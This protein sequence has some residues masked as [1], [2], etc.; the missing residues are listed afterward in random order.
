[1]LSRRKKKGINTVSSI[2]FLLVMKWEATRTKQ[3]A[4]DQLTMF[5]PVCTK[6]KRKKTENCKTRKVE[7][8][9]LKNN[10]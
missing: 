8:V 6:R 9:R 1:M 3:K 2:V 10:F 7:F 4:L 5:M